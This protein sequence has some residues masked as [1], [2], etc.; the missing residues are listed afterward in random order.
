MT[1]HNSRNHHTDIYK[2][3]N[4]RVIEK[5]TL[6]Y[7]SSY[8]FVKN[9]EFSSSVVYVNEC[10]ANQNMRQIQRGGP[11]KKLNIVFKLLAS[12]FFYT[13]ICAS[14]MHAYIYSLRKSRVLTF[15]S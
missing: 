11:G 3:S 5:V 13:Y 12:H 7:A 9:L 15:S 2:V 10:L 4:N 1:A 6:I 14:F 8:D